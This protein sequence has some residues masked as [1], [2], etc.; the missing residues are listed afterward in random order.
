MNADGSIK[1]ELRTQLLFNLLQ[2]S[3]ENPGK[4]I[5]DYNKTDH[6]LLSVL[7]NSKKLSDSMDILSKIPGLDAITK[8]L[9][10]RAQKKMEETARA[11]TNGIAVNDTLVDKTKSEGDLEPAK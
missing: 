5:T 1:Q 6:P 11:V 8:G 7:E 3:A 10:A 9:A 2:V 4:L